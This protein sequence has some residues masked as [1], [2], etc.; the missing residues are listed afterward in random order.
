MM[1][2][3]QIRAI[4]VFGD[5]TGFGGF[6]QRITHPETEFKPFIKWFDSLIGSFERETG[7][8]LKR[9]GDGFMCVVELSSHNQSK[10]A[11]SLIDS[12]WDLVSKINRSIARMPSPRPDGFRS[13]MVCGYVWRTE[14]DDNREDYL[15]YHVNLAAKLIKQDREHIFVCHESVKELLTKKQIHDYGYVFDKLVPGQVPPAGV[16]Q[17][18]INSLWTVKR[19]GR[20]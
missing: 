8:F 16:Y 4:V 9:L 5:I 17:Q 12:T 7:Y 6:M 3:K 2:E 15:G 13:R 20:P 18:D 10:Q 19:K 1:D 14:R 11:I